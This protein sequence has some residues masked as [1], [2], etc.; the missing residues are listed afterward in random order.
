ME[1]EDEEKGETRVLEEIDE[2]LYIVEVFFL[3]NPHQSYIKCLYILY[4]ILI[5][6]KKLQFYSY[7]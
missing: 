2:Q 1:A 3:Q 4:Q 7:F 5:H 6:Y